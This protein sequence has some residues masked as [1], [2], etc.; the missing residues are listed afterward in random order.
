MI[1]CIPYTCRYSQILGVIGVL[2]T[3]SSLYCRNEKDVQDADMAHFYS[4][5]SGS[6]STT[7][8]KKFATKRGYEGRLQYLKG[9]QITGK[10]DYSVNV[11][12]F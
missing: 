9:L 4:R 8:G 2:L 7:I 1:K 10:K 3:F 11:A 6:I 12:Q 5:S